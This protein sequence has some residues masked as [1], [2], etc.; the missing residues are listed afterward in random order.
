MKRIIWGWE[1]QIDLRE[2]KELRE[3]M[4]ED[5][6]TTDDLDRGKGGVEAGAKEENDGNLGLYFFFVFLI[7]FVDFFFWTLGGIVATNS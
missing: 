2:T 4:L 1:K 5:D 3:K 6:K 7:F